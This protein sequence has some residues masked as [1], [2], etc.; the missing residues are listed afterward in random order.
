MHAPS[1]VAGS[2]R[3]IDEPRRMRIGARGDQA[4]ADP[5]MDII[6]IKER[7]AWPERDGQTPIFS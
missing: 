5:P 6:D 1:A 2:R 7:G 3:L 4:R